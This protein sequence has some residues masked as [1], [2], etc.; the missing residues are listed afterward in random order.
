MALAAR[1]QPTANA[2]QQLSATCFL[3][4]R[5]GGSL[6]QR[7]ELHL[8][9]RTLHVQQQP[10]VSL[11]CI[12]DTVFIDDERINQPAELEQRVPVSAVASQP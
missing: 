8:R 1:T 12:V 6:P 5:L 9:E 2:H 7:Q 10:V 3:H 11:P 4:Q